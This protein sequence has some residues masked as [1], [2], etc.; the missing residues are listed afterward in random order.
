MRFSRVGT[1]G[2][3]LTIEAGGETIVLDDFTNAALPFE[4][5][6]LL[7]VYAATV[8]H[9]T[10][11]PP[12][13]RLD[14]EPGGWVLRSRH[15]SR[16][17]LDRMQIDILEGDP[18]RKETLETEPVTRIS[19]TRDVLAGSVVDAILA[20]Q[21]LDASDNGA[22]LWLN[23]PYRAV[24]AIM[25]AREAPAV[26]LRRLTTQTP[27][28][29][30]D[31][32]EIRCEFSDFGWVDIDIHTDAGVTRIEGVSHI[33]ATFNDF[34]AAALAIATGRDAPVDITAE[35]EPGHTVIAIKTEDI[36]HSTFYERRCVLRVSIEHTHYGNMASFSV[37]TNVFVCAVC[38][39]LAGIRDEMGVDA[40]YETYEE[41]FPAKALAAL[42]AAIRTPATPMPAPD[43][44]DALNIKLPASA[45]PDESKTDD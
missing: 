9:S 35:H 7:G 30:T 1:T 44:T 42:E 10:N 13:V 38:S 18:W 17:P 19:M 27:P 31:R 45:E 14:I 21:E 22:P 37:N 6:A 8:T 15:D 4:S 40:F 11:N 26:H 32:F 25:A 34:A 23:F 33:R 3:T 24:R 43:I 16:A 36:E 5:L 29:D 12:L 39:M 20:A 2:W 28:S 41:E